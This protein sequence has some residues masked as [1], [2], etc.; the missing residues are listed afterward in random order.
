MPR[1]STNRCSFPH[2]ALDK[3]PMTAG[4]AVCAALLLIGCSRPVPV[5]EDVRPVRVLKVEPARTSAV[6]EFSGEVRPRVESRVGFQVAG[7]ITGRTAEV[8][9]RVQRGQTLA[10]LDASDYQLSAT[11]ARLQVE[12]AKVDRDQQR[13]DYKRFEDLAARGFISGADLERRK[14]QLDS[15]EARYNATV[16]QA[17]VS[18]NQAA[19]S[20]LKAPTA[21]VITA[22]EAEVGQV[23]AAGQAVVRIAQTEQKEVAIAIPENRLA[24]LSRIPEVKVTLWAGEGELRGRVREIAPQADPATRTYPARIMLIDAPPNV[25]LGMTASVRFEVPLPQPIIALPLQALLR[26]GDATYVWLLD[27]DTQK[28]KKSRIEIADVAGS[29]VVVRSGVA[30]GAMVV[31]AGVHLLKEG[32]KVRVLD[33]EPVAPPAATP[34]PTAKAAQPTQPVQ[35]ATKGKD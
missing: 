24:I 30:H 28:V 13:A 4:V 25:A 3:L 17:D 19:Y 2:L 23:V 32:Q 26:E 33:A 20:V 11:A 34:V 1:R 6:A 8:G 22:I 14:A 31:T 7:R 29:D 35:P 9:Q 10:T 16:A 15:A 12:S 18:G 5:T 27:Q 21:G